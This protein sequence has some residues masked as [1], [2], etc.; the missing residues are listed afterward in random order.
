MFRKMVSLYHLFLSVSA[1]VLG[2]Y[3][4]FGEGSFDT[5]PNEWV[6]TM[7]FSSWMSL[8]I[9]GMIL[10]GI[11]NILM[12]A[13]GFLK[14]GKNVYIGAMVLGLLLCLGASLPGILLGEGYLPIVYLYVAGIL[15]IAL[16]L[17]G[18]VSKKRQKAYQ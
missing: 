13:L 10:L 15:Q 6:G 11:G 7:P 8:A 12:T 4:L 2:T 5:F 17:V 9:V 1:F 14:R 16:G 18:I 3:M